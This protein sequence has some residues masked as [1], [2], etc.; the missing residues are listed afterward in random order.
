MSTQGLIMNKKFIIYTI[1]A[2]FLTILGFINDIAWFYVFIAVFFEG[3]Y[4]RKI[5]KKDKDKINYLGIIYFIIM[6]LIGISATGCSIIAYYL[7][8]FLIF[9]WIIINGIYFIFTKFEILKNNKMK[10][11]LAIIIV[12]LMSFIINKLIVTKIPYQEYEAQSLNG[13][14]NNCIKVIENMEDLDNL[15]ENKEIL[16]LEWSTS[17]AETEINATDNYVNKKIEEEKKKLIETFKIDDDFFN[18]YYIIFIHNLTG[19]TAVPLGVDYITYN[20]MNKEIHLVQKDIPFAAEGSSVITYK[21][22]FIKI[23]KKYMG[24][25]NWKTKYDLVNSINYVFTDI[26]DSIIYYF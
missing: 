1:L 24:E 10:I 6:I 13:I 16:S 12:V 15:L 14:F 22:S 5:Y 18:E 21:C 25:I 4:I 20:R 26:I 3:Y 9:F 17:I 19:N 2:I 23:D 7:F 8:V 11:I